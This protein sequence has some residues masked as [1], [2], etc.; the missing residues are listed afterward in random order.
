MDVPVESIVYVN[1]DTDTVPMCLGGF[2][3]RAMFIGG[4]AAIAA[5]KDLKEKIKTF[6]APMLGVEAD[7]LEIGDGKVFVKDDPEKAQTLAEIGGAAN[8]SGNFLVGTAPTCRKG[9]LRPRLRILKPGPCPIW[10]PLHTPP[11]LSR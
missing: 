8:F 7:Q 2:A 11:V 1:T 4:N 5:C 9:G 10:P 3:S 6:S